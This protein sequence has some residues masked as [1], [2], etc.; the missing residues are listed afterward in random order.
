MLKNSLSKFENR[1]HR[2]RNRRLGGDV[3]HGRQVVGEE[4]MR[5]SQRGLPDLNAISKRSTAVETSPTPLFMFLMQGVFRV[6]WPF[7]ASCSTS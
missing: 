5:A 7:T 4:P 6:A 1:I 2:L 3:R